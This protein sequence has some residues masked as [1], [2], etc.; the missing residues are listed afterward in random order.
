MPRTSHKSANKGSTNKQINQP[1]LANVLV[2][3]IINETVSVFGFFRVTAVFSEDSQIFL[4][5][6]VYHSGAQ[7]SPWQRAGLGV[8][9]ALRQGGGTVNTEG[10]LMPS[11]KLKKPVS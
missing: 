4:L 8:G 1:N 3:V 2:K 9:A 7:S 11:V 10:S 5:S 6:Y